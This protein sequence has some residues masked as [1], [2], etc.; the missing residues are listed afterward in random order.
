MHLGL[1]A[2]AK[3]DLARRK[4][5]NANIDARTRTRG[6]TMAAN[7]PASSP[8]L[9]HVSPSRAAS[10]G[11]DRLVDRET[12]S[13]ELRA[14]QPSP[15]K[16]NSKV[17]QRLHSA[18]DGIQSVGQFIEAQVAAVT[19]DIRASS[20]GGWNS[21]TNDNVAHS[22]HNNKGKAE[23]PHS[24][25]DVRRQPAPAF[26][27]VLEQTEKE[28]SAERTRDRPQSASGAL[29]SVGQ[30]AP[31][32]RK[33]VE[34]SAPEGKKS[35]FTIYDG[36]ERITVS[37][38][39]PAGS[40]RGS[41]ANGDL[42]DFQ[43]LAVEQALKQ[44]S[45]ARLRNSPLSPKRPKQV[46]PGV[47]NGPE[48]V[49]F[50]HSEDLTRTYSEKDVLKG[51]KKGPTSREPSSKQLQPASL[52][53]QKSVSFQGELS[54]TEAT[55]GFH[56]VGAV[57]RKGRDASV[58]LGKVT[59]AQVQG[60][61]A[62]SAAK[63]SPEGASGTAHKHS[64]H[65]VAAHSP[66]S[67]LRFPLH[68]AAA[69]HHNRG[70]TKEAAKLLTVNTALSGD[71]SLL[72]SAPDS[73]EE[74]PPTEAE[75][76]AMENL[77][78]VE[79]GFSDTFNAA[80]GLQRQGS[81]SSA[82]TAE[83]APKERQHDLKGLKLRSHSGLETRSSAIFRRL[84]LTPKLVGYTSEDTQAC[85]VPELY[86]VSVFDVGY[87]LPCSNSTL[88]F[89]TEKSK[90]NAELIPKSSRSV[91]KQVSSR[92][93]ST[94]D[95]IAQL[96][97]ERDAEEESLFLRTV[98][99]MARE[100]AASGSSKKVPKP[101]GLLSTKS[102][103]P[104]EKLSIA[105]HLQET[106]EDALATTYGVLIEVMAQPMVQSRQE[107]MS[108]THHTTFGDTPL[109][110]GESLRGEESGRDGKG[111]APHGGGTASTAN[112]Q[113]SSRRSPATYTHKLIPLRE[114]YDLAVRT[115]NDEMTSLVG[116]ML[117]FAY[118]FGEATNK[119]SSSPELEHRRHLQSEGDRHQNDADCL[120]FPDHKEVTIYPCLQNMLD[121][122]T[123][124]ALTHLVKNHVELQFNTDEECVSVV[125][126]Q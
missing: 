66:V 25:Y 110:R 123:K 126:K 118:H 85:G 64:A 5:Q 84:E 88:H 11:V 56:G 58:R 14:T 98:K 42:I 125:I 75:L 76:R 16:Q 99:D 24:A 80:A 35:E 102:Q 67:T 114:L 29:P 57:P 97:A 40:F 81:E 95:S 6:Q 43:A 27:K 1:V 124:R 65:S 93:L 44:G 52:A 26:K 115:R 4:R 69:D 119:R 107:S 53:S 34:V 89:S 87:V 15:T 112:K 10:T 82:S 68:G 49:P 7:R 21:S 73:L 19:Q 50:P 113:Q 13:L 100:T 70:L 104:G 39:Y 36:K 2:K 59:A 77:D 41:G 117:R 45:A 55:A 86:E 78:D 37:A 106:D 20:E 22:M 79:D 72:A 108:T 111:G 9:R 71:L 83:A 120:T 121:R 3:D 31:T 90:D 101:Y 63:H 74:R 48:W 91:M 8:H 18:V 122:H 17:A 28:K 12:P 30:S 105:Q 94:V 47:E 103:Q 62:L 92:R 60:P 109:A 96:M 32:R 51:S 116:E 46:F 33:Y 54:H 61:G 38:S 23:R